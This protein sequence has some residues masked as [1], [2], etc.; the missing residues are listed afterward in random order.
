MPRY[1]TILEQLEDLFPVGGTI[2]FFLL[3][4][5]MLVLK[6]ALYEDL[7]RSFDLLL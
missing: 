3:G 4:T 1:L 5:E 7:L 2:C 6:I